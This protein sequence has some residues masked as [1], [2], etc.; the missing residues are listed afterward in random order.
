MPRLRPTAAL[1]IAATL[2]L[3]QE[4]PIFRTT[5][6][7]VVV[8]VEVRSRDGKPVEGL[9]AEDFEI[10]ESKQPQRISVFEYQRLESEAPATPAA[11][12]AAEEARS[13][14]AISASKPGELRYRDRRLIMLYF[15]V[16]ALAVARRA[17]GCVSEGS[18]VRCTSPRS[19]AR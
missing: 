6:N 13:A 10:L 9:K 5:T 15:D 19:R 14:P 17:T 7:L 2:A 18:A 3:P 1:L 16:S 8:N 11:V 4:Q 12:A